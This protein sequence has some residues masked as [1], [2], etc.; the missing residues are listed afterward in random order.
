MEK[1]NL[2]INNLIKFT[3]MKKLVFLFMLVIAIAKLHGQSYYEITFTGTG[4][5]P[6]TVLVENLTKGTS[7]NMQGDDILHLDIVSVGIQDFAS[8]NNNLS[9]YPNPVDYTCHFEFSNAQQGMVNIQLYALDGRKV[10]EYSREH[11]QGRHTFMLSGI[12]AGAYIINIQTPCDNISGRFVSTGKSKADLSLAHSGEMPLSKNAEN[13]EA[14][15]KT[16]TN[17]PKTKGTKAIVNMDFSIGD[18]L[19]FIGIATGFLNDTIYVSP[20]NDQTITFQFIELS[21]GY[22]CPGIHTFTDVRDGSVYSTVQIGNQCWMAENL[23]YLPSVVGS[24]NNSD[25]TPYYFVY[26]YQG[27][28]VN[29]A[30]ATTNYTTYGVLYNW[31]AAMNEAASS[32]SNPSGVQGACPPGWHLPSNAEWTQLTDYLGGESVAGGKLKA[33][34]LWNIPNAGATNESGFSALPGGNRWQG[35]TFSDIEGIGYWWCATEIETSDAWYRKV[36]NSNSNVYR[37]FIEKEHGF[38]IRCIKN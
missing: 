15:S 14:E 34:I 21:Y 22:P 27:T 33:T 25:E 11:T 13:A 23:R 2:I 7:V 1:N 32:S 29:A 28:D 5:I 35:G 17:S 36:R 6:E 37:F 4:G 18:E 8:K 26:G 12:S 9:I 30:K 38:S 20:T 31:P 10:Y 16:L 24:D 19:Q 3:P